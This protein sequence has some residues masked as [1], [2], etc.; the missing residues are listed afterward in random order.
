M[1]RKLRTDVERAKAALAVADRRVTRLEAQ[2]AALVGQ[3]D[4]AESLLGEAR[5]RRN[6]LGSDPAILAEQLPDAG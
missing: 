1:T 5:V 4:E 2:V 3:L 6:Y